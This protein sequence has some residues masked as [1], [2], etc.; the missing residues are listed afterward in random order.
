MFFYYNKRQDLSMKKETGKQEEQQRTKGGKLGTIFGTILCIILIPIL[1]I[2]VTMIIK[3]Y[4]NTSKVP[5]FLG[6]APMIVLTDSMFP[7]IESGDLII[8]KTVDASQIREQDIISFFDPAGS[9]TSVVTHRV[10]H[11][12]KENGLAFITKGDGNNAEDSDPVPAENLVGLYQTHIS[13]A[14]NVAMFLQTT[15]GLV[16]CVALPM[17]LLIAYELIRRKKYEKHKDDD[18]KA[19][20]AELEALRA[21]QAAAETTPDNTSSE[22]KTE[23]EKKTEELKPEDQ[24]EAE[25]AEPDAAPEAEAA[26]PETAAEAEPAEASDPEST[27]DPEPKAETPAL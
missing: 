27:K 13:G 12:S 26:E 8:V 17:V 2:N 19:L 7:T 3:G 1:I 22:Q 21:K 4:T 15:P 24:P 20:L 10:M 5:T 9:G 16:V 18:T 14:G 6:Y 25:A 11:I 23:P